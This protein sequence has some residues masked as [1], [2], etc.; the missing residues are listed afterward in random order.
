MDD[1]KWNYKN[2]KDFTL[3]DTLEAE[4]EGFYSICKDGKVSILTND[5]DVY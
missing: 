4:E 2:I 5:E 1:L 3:E